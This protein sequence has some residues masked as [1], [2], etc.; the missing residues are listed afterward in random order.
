[1]SAGDLLRLPDDGIRHELIAGELHELALEGG[2]HGYVAGH[3]TGGRQRRLLA[4]LTA[5][6]Q[7]AC[8]QHTRLRP[9]RF[10]S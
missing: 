6:G 4:A 7:A 10:A 1:M 9:A 2:E 3:A 8:S 5:S